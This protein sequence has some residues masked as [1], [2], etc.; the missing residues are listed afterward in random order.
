MIRS[1]A[2]LLA[3]AVLTSTAHSQIIIN[4]SL[5]S[6]TGEGA[7]WRLGFAAGDLT[8]KQEKFLPRSGKGYVLMAS[9]SS[10]L[11]VSIH[12]S[13][14]ERTDP[15]ELRELAH[16]RQAASGVERT[17]VVRS[18]GDGFATIAY[19]TPKFRD[20]EINQRNV[21]VHYFKEGFWIDVH[22][23]KVQFEPADQKLFDT[24]IGSL[25]FAKKSAETNARE[26][27][28]LKMWAEAGMA[29]HG[30]DF[31]KAK[32]IY[33]TVLT[34]EQQERTLT[35]SYW[36][37]LVDNLGM[38]QAMTGDLPGAEKTFMYGASADPT[39][40]MFHYNL[41]CTYAEMEDLERTIPALR[42]AIAL[43]ANMIDGERFP[44]PE[45][46][47]SF[48][49]FRDDVSFRAVIDEM[50]TSEN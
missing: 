33:G 14:A 2:L 35:Q 17:D 47:S 42:R 26:A 20:V 21:Q 28:V 6:V 15:A 29:F 23:S 43:R 25:A 30:N 37:V 13:P 36:K 22:M 31:A 48:E 50:K 10:G 1:V 39:Y 45:R 11:T 32:E 38:A 9:A 16:T 27:G 49:R 44:D 3:I 19:T 5:G 34:M 18:E 12:V 41:A 46:D 8:I 40:A 7:L 4:E 24:F